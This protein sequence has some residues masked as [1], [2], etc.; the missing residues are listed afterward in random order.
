MRCL[1]MCA[2]L[3]SRAVPAGAAIVDRLAIALG[4][5]V[6]TASEID[7]RIRLTAFQN[8]EKPDF[9]LESRR[10]AAQRL[11][12][13]KLVEREME[14]G[15]YPQLDEKTRKDLVAGYEKTNYP[16]NPAAMA[17]ALRAYDLAPRD[18]ENDL[19]H[20]AALLTF[21]NL[22]FRPAVQVTDQEVQKYF[23][24]HYRDKAG[25]GSLHDMRAGI[26]QKLTA[27]RAGQELDSWLQA[28]R[29]STA[30]DYVEKDLA[31]PETGGDRK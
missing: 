3:F 22:R 2:I 18:L 8:G 20:Q 6:I 17:A 29:H 25:A 31:P 9:S 13:Q 24:E 12:D 7:L 16:S 26:E 10:A 27:D 11:L 23:T 30:I 19:A 21:L 1:Q 14:V 4:N 5:K 28:Q 15:H